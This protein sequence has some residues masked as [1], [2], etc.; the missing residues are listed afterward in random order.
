MFSEF[1]ITGEWSTAQLTVIL[2]ISA[3]QLSHMSAQIP[4]TAE[5]PFTQFALQDTERIYFTQRSPSLSPKMVELWNIR[6]VTL[7]T[8]FL[9]VSGDLYK[10]VKKGWREIAIMRHS[11][12]RIIGGLRRMAPLSN[13]TLPMMDLINPHP[14]YLDMFFFH[15]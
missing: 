14:N 1:V 5:P 11:C 2:S 10:A 13:I 7:Q 3:M 4:L 12:Q 9:F 6:Q 15:M 8:H